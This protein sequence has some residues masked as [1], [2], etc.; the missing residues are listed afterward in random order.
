MISMA[1]EQLK[2]LDPE[3]ENYKEYKQRFET[4]IELYSGKEIDVTSMTLSAFESVVYKLKLDDKNMK[5]AEMLMLADEKSMGGYTFEYN[6]NGVMT[7]ST[8][9]DSDGD[10]LEAEYR[11]NGT[12]SSFKYTTDEEVLN[13][14]CDENGTVTEITEE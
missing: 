12:P 5:I 7:R 6:A 3:D 10:I 13:F 2:L 11:A 1:K 14:T 4:M 9:L 8:E